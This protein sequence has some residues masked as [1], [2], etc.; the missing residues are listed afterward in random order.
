MSPSERHPE[1]LG[2][3]G[4]GIRFRSPRRRNLSQRLENQFLAEA[5]LQPEA[6]E[7]KYKNRHTGELHFI[8]DFLQRD[9]TDITGAS[10]DVTKIGSAPRRIL[11]TESMQAARKKQE[12]ERKGWTADFLGTYLHWL[13]W[14]DNKSACHTANIQRNSAIANKTKRSMAMRYHDVFFPPGHSGLTEED[15]VRALAE[16]VGQVVLHR[17]VASTKENIRRS[18]TQTAKQQQSLRHKRSYSAPKSQPQT[19]RYLTTFKYVTQLT[20]SQGR[21][22]FGNLIDPSTDERSRIGPLEAVVAPTAA[23]VQGTGTS[24]AG[25]STS[26]LLSHPLCGF[27]PCNTFQD[28]FM[29]GLAHKSTIQKDLLHL[30]ESDFATDLKHAL[31][32]FSLADPPQQ[33]HNERQR[34]GVLHKNVQKWNQ[35]VRRQIRIPAQTTEPFTLIDEDPTEAENV[36]SKDVAW[37]FNPAMLFEKAKEKENIYTKMSAKTAA[38]INHRQAFANWARTSGNDLRCS[39]LQEW[40]GSLSGASQEQRRVQ[41]VNGPPYFGNGNDKVNNDL[42]TNQAVCRIENVQGLAN[43]MAAYVTQKHVGKKFVLLNELDLPKPAFYQSLPPWL[44]FVNAG[45][46]SKWEA[47]RITL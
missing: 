18:I 34:P 45:N 46:L 32:D 9:F 14:S 44:G 24:K 17:I 27:A 38:V 16:T 25:A 43:G 10:K 36:G 30:M 42:A 29:Q 33:L 22:A 21:I 23:T 28:L 3:S 5:L 20:D 12:G 7:K 40:S 2:V 1:S 47:G 8:S 13:K 41:W 37:D 39:D 4:I 11:E 31:T 15:Q 35:R 6:V 19:F 26:D